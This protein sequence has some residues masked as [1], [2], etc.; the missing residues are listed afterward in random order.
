MWSGLFWQKWRRTL[1]VL[2]FLIQ[3]YLRILLLALRYRVRKLPRAH[4]ASLAYEHWHRLCQAL[5]C[6]QT[7]KTALNSTRERLECEPLSGKLRSIRQNLENEQLQRTLARARS[8]LIQLIFIEECP[9][10]P[11]KRAGAAQTH[12]ALRIPLAALRAMQ[13]W[14]KTLKTDATALITAGLASLLLVIL[15]AASGWLNQTLYTMQ[16][17]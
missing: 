15:F 14:L 7:F 8:A 4:I 10:R 13:G 17:L 5:N 3:Y 1:P 16:H 12:N 11:L 6:A 9:T 2:L